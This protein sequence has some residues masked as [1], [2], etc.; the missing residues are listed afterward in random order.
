[1]RI[2]ND[3]IGMYMDTYFEDIGCYFSIY[4][5]PF[6]LNVYNDNLNGQGI[7]FQIYT[8][9]LNICMRIDDQF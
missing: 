4:L 9:T 5:F 2:G 6:K 1:M 8:L 3:F 7:E